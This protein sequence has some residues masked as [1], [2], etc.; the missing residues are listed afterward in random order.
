MRHG[1][2]M[3][4]G[5]KE[6][7]GDAANHRRK[8][9]GERRRPFERRACWRMMTT[10][11][12]SASRRTHKGG[13]KSLESRLPQLDGFRAIAVL[14]VM[15]SHAGL[16]H[17]VPGGLGVTVFCFLRGYPLTSIMVHEW[18]RTGQLSFSK[19]YLRR[20]VRIIPPMLIAI[21]FTVLLSAA[22]LI[23]A[24]NYPSL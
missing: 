13:A 18:S 4:W 8:V 16:E 5:G 3:Q 14:L 22:G 21:G 19:F 20:T 7:R 6:R 9:A 23:A 17:I 10:A 12:K 1:V 2:R 11:R 15:I 24:M